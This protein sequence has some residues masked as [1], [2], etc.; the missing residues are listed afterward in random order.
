MN[1]NFSALE[2]LHRLGESATHPIA[3]PWR[4]LGVLL[5]LAGSSLLP[6][7]AYPAHP[8]TPHSGASNCRFQVK[9]KPRAH[10]H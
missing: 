4:G 9:R 8:M 3:P 1:I 5:V 7:L 10:H 2:E 6:P